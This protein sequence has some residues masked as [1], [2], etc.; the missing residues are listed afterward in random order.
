MRLWKSVVGKLWL[1]ILLLVTAVL[2]I[3]TIM[4][5]EFFEDY[6]LAILEKELTEEA[7]KIAL[8][9]SNYDKEQGLE[10]VWK[11]V[12]NYNKVFIVY[13]EN[14][15]YEP[16]NEIN[17]F[18]LSIDTLL[19][20]T[21]FINVIEN[22][23]T[24]QKV[25]PYFVNKGIHY[26]ESKYMVVGVPLDNSTS[27]NGGVFLYRS[28]NTLEETTKTTTKFIFFVAAV[29][30]ILTT[31]F[32][33]FLS[34][35]ITSP[36]RNL[37][38][39]AFEI[40]RGRF[41]NKIY[42]PANDEI[43]ELAIAFNQMGKQ[44][45]FNMNAL[46]QEKEQLKNILSA[47]ADGVITFNKDGTILITN[48]PAERFLQQWF[49]ERSLVDRNNLEVPASLMELFN[50]VVETGKEQVREIQLQNQS[51][52]IIISPLYT[53]D[54]IRGAVAV[55]RD[56]TEERR[57]DKLRQ[58]FIVNVSHELRTPISMMQGYSEAIMDGIAETEEEKNE[59]VRVIYDESV[60]MS[61]LVNELLNLAKLESGKAE[62]EIV[63]VEVE[64][65]FNKTV[66][67]FSALAKE[68]G[69]QLDCFID[70]SI[71][72]F[73]F[74]PFAI[75]QVMTNL[76]G[77]AIRHTPAGGK[78]TCSI[79]FDEREMIVE[80][81]DTGNGI[82][83]ADIP[84]VFERFY[85]AD[86]ARTRNTTGTGL[87]LSIVKNIVRAHKGSINCTSKINEGTAFIFTIPRYL[88]IE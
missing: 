42:Y 84:F 21:D 33:F 28:L 13:N 3:L 10:F 35:R 5:L 2:F 25:T 43:G 66:R 54:K 47:M 18:E 7:N 65:Y 49:K 64:S 56:M 29:A 81:K 31:I 39:G 45:K 86:K 55:I 41:D 32:A 6:H 19:K 75:E 23:Q 22:N 78:I 74:D 70:P 62:L 11:T 85:K 73:H 36:L 14:E 26:S 68:N 8:I 80:V 48:P 77:N 60:R 53:Y 40:A 69:I 15:I 16:P 34:T 76:I 20:N 88:S 46:N 52:V 71:A 44:L 87:G 38:E 61:R 82:D 27:Q 50:V 57:L 72:F 12:G 51:W 1:T 9:L 24:I 59:M 63:E 17:K 79:Y 37:R 30:I 4:L 67:K 58:D 83:E